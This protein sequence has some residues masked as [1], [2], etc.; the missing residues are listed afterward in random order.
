M[1]ELQPILDFLGVFW[2]D[3]AIK[4][5]L[6]T[7]LVNSLTAVAAAVHTGN[8]NFHRLGGFLYRK[9]LPYGGLYCGYWVIG[10]AIDLSALTT[11]AFGAVEV[12]LA[13]DLIESL[14]ELGL[15]V[16]ERLQGAVSKE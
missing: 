12:A 7:V 11:V 13:A 9:I 1:E 15:K 5:I 4:W 16:P 2:Q 3:S 6:L 14:G 10:R 8:F